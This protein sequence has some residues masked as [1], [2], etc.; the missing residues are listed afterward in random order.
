VLLPGADRA[1]DPSYR[2][3]TPFE[4]IGG[5]VLMRDDDWWHVLTPKLDAIRERVGPDEQIL[6]LTA[7][8]LLYVML[9]RMGPGRS[10]IVM[11]G[12]FLDESEEL[13]FV[14]RLE[15]QPPAL[16]IMRTQPFDEMRSRSLARIA[17]HLM[18]WISRHYA[19]VGDPEDYV[20]L[21][22]RRLREFPG[23]PAEAP[24][25]ESAVASLGAFWQEDADRAR[26]RLELLPLDPGNGA[27]RALL[28]LMEDL[29]TRQVVDLLRTFSGVE[30]SLGWGS[31]RGSLAHPGLGIALDRR[32]QR[33]VES[34]SK[35]DRVLE[36]ARFLLA[37]QLAHLMQLQIYSV[38]SL[39]RAAN[40][41]RVEAQADLLAGITLVQNRIFAERGWVGFRADLERGLELA[42][43]IGH[44]LLPAPFPLRDEERRHLLRIGAELGIFYD[45]AWTCITNVGE[46]GGERH[47]REVLKASA[48][49][50]QTVAQMFS[51]RPEPGFAPRP[52][53]L[54]LPRLDP[55][56]QTEDVFDWT[57][58]AAGLALGAP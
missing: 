33:R 1:F 3:S 44:A 56:C 32:L 11:P 31:Q 55:R 13:S 58:R 52:E 34:E 39:G 22:P 37:H 21:A 15:E 35:R 49:T 53:G 23:P 30:T 47:V 5:D 29:E 6:D 18:S 42:R 25:A 46:P 50:R 14:A 16:A 12:T 26:A 43:E 36:A 24:A 8:S 19:P 57:S 17:P 41:R 28:E 48:Q 27:D 9:D 54:A 7:Q 20:L 38:E 10:D 4:P 40:L 2:G 51:G 45:L